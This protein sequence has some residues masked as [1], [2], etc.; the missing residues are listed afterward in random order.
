M[1]AEDGRYS[2]ADLTPDRIG[3]FSRELGDKVRPNGKKRT[4][5]TVVRYMAALSHVLNTALKEWGWLEK[6]PMS[7]V[8]KPKVDNGRA[9]FISGDQCKRLL[10]AARRSDNDKLHTI[11]LLALSTGM[12]YS[13][14]LTLRW[15]DVIPY[16]AEGMSLFV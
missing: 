13:E 11:V 3:K 9:R 12:R 1:G 15:R 5:S 2:A 6:S 4:A 10:D 14:I 8:R 16:S 7:S